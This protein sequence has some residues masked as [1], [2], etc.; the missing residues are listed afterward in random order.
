MVYTD[1]PLTYVLTSAK[2]NVVGQRW[3]NDLAN[4]TIRYKP[5]KENIDAD[6]LSRK[7]IDISKLKHLCSES[8]SSH[9]EMC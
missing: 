2:L 3:V 1:N 8:I 5:G 4:F 9:M 7:F 6:F